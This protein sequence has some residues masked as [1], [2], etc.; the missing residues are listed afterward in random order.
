MKDFEKMPVKEEKPNHPTITM[1]DG[2]LI[3]KKG[4]KRILSSWMMT[5]IGAIALL[6][7]LIIFKADPYRKIFFFVIKGTPTTFEITIAAII[8]A[9]IIGTLTGIGSV[10]N[11]R[12][13]TSLCGVY[14]ELIR[15]IPLLVQLMFLYFA[16]GSI[17]HMEGNIAAIVALSICF[18]AYMGEIV[19]AGIQAIPKG[20]TEAATALGLTKAQTFMHVILPQTIKIVLPAIG[21]EF[22]SMLKDSSLVSVLALSDILKKGREYISRTFLSLQTMLIVA[23]IYL[24]FTLVLSRLVGLM[25]ER[26]HKNG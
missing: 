17:I 10:S 18:G 16:L 8:G 24:I 7:F 1:T 12:L 3:P 25:E 9:V 11:N 22:I 26:L 21:N 5:F 13:I 15:G 4:N 6:L 14:V 19:R 20:Q 2:V 23:L